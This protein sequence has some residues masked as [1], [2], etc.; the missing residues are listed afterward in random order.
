M[1]R[2]RLRAARRQD[3]VHWTSTT[4]IPTEGADEG[5]N[6]LAFRRRGWAL[7]PS[8]GPA[9]TRPGGGCHGAQVTARRPSLRLSWPHSASRLPALSQPVGSDY[10]TS[11]SLPRTRRR[12][13]RVRLCDRQRP[14]RHP[15]G[16]LPG[17]PAVGR[18]DDRRAP[19]RAAAGCPDRGQRGLGR[20]DRHRR[21]RRSG[22]QSLSPPAKPQPPSAPSPEPA[23]AHS[24]VDLRGANAFRHSFTAVE[25]CVGCCGPC[26]PLRRRLRTAPACSWLGR[27]P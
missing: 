7:A 27:T 3:E 4:G 6:G 8:R 11:K 10:Q 21:D 17:H 24:R 9:V 19:H 22:T 1:T 12:Q 15:G 18:Q 2:V 25:G 13:R 5:G 26:S 16:Q 14:L 20:V 23:W